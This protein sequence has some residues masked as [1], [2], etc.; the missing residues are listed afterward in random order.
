MIEIGNRGLAEAALIINQ[1]CSL[2]FTIIHKDD[3]NDV[4]DHSQ[5][6]GH[7]A[8]QKGKNTYR[9][10]NTINCNDDNIVVSITPED[11]VNIKPGEY[12]WDLIVEMQNGQVLRLLY[13]EAYI[14]DTYALD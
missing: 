11:I 1:N 7:I 13:G 9:L 3:G 14:I 12:L 2:T 8:L 4:I 6:V 10:D 5:S